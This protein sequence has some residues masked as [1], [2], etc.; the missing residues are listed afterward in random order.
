L[1]DFH[2]VQLGE[3]HPS[4]TTHGVGHL[5]SDN[6]LF[7]GEVVDH[8][9]TLDWIGSQ[10]RATQHAAKPRQDSELKSR[11]QN[12]HDLNTCLFIVLAGT[13][14]SAELVVVDS[15]VVGQLEKLFAVR[16]ADSML[17]ADPVHRAF[18]DLH[19][20]TSR[21][22]SSVVTTSFIAADAVLLASIQMCPM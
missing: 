10:S 19:G 22:S 2:D 7:P 21:F 1:D 9:T 8:Q 5:A 20:V 11:A 17:F 13:Q 16:R 18:V 3:P 15:A 6:D 4:A 14:A 12:F